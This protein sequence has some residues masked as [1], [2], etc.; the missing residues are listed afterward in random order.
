MILDEIA[1]KTKERV[2]QNKALCSTAQLRAL[3]EEQQK[4]QRQRLVK[5]K[6]RLTFADVLRKP[7]MTF[8]CE[9]KKASPSKGVIAET[10]PYKEIAREYEQA[11]ADCL[12]VLTEPYYFLGQ[13]SYLK[14][15][16]DTVQLPILRKDFVVDE[17]MIYEAKVMKADAILLICAILE[18]RQLKAYHE[19]ANSLG[20][21]V[22]VEAHDAA[23]I[24]MAL[25]ADAK[26]IGVNNRNLK[27]FSVDFQNT[28]RLRH[29]VPKDRLFVSESGI[30]TAD[31]IRRLT[32]AEVDAVLIGETLM[33]QGDKAKA[34]QELKG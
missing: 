5:E 1:E 3:C 29:L 22:L 13:D 12:S 16:R 2:K 4:E 31:D 21:S 6:E 25:G 30:R 19:L 18:P 9:V 17:Y 32:E 24:E 27:D 15:I 23:E 28:L 20:L 26:I 8:I 14:E 33:R 34:L 10:F 11:G 7:G